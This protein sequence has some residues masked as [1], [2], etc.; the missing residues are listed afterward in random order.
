M[1]SKILVAIDQP[2]PSQ[3]ALDLVRQLATDGVTEVRVLHLRERELSGYRWVARENR[4]RASFV[5]E[6]AIF[7]LRMEGFAAGGVVRPAIV[8]R[9]AEGILD[10]A[11][12]F[13]ADLIVLGG[14]QRGEFLARL[15]GSIT[16][17]VLRRSACPVIVAP[18]GAR[19]RAQAVAP[20]SAPG[21]HS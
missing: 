14:P 16:I 6:S 8:D 7:E 18:R 17:R 20:Y 9:V 3:A 10:E 19:G 4:D 5:A 13:G 12:V 21:Q 2:E 15:F 11:R 1:F